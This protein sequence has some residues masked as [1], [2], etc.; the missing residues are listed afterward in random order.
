MSENNNIGDYLNSGESRLTNSFN[1]QIMMLLKDDAVER[2]SKWIIDSGANVCI[3]N[4]KA[5]FSEFQK[6][7]YTVGTA[8]NGGLHI[9]G[10]GTVLLKLTSD[11]HDLVELELHNVAYAQDA[12]CNILSLSWITERVKLTGVWGIKGI[13]IKTAEGFEIGHASLI[14]GLFHL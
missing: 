4:D 14:D 1:P 6:V 2:S 12:R 10:A 5:W 7:I 8:N 11:K 3:A 9:E 13:S